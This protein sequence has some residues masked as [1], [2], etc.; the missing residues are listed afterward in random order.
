MKFNRAL[1]ALLM[2]VFALAVYSDSREYKEG[3]VLQSKKKTS[4]VVLFKSKNDIMTYQIRKNYDNYAWRGYRELD[5]RSTYDLEKGD[6]II[7]LKKLEEGKIFMVALVKRKKSNSYGN[8]YF[9]VDP[10]S[11]KNLAFSEHLT[12]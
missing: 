9:Y 3:D 10:R 1:S 4:S 2:L 7:L 11:F 6:K 8:T 5:G 12:E